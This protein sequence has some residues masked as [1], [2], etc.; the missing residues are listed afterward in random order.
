MFDSN[1]VQNY[2][3]KNS[4]ENTYHKGMHKIWNGRV[5]LPRLI[6]KYAGVERSLS[7]DQRGALK[8]ILSLIIWGEYAAWQTSNYLASDIKEYSAKMAA[9]SQAHDEA[10]HYFTMCDYIRNILDVSTDNVKISSVGMV[11]LESVVM[12]DSLAKRLL[13][14]QLMVEPVAITI[15]HKLRELDVEPVL[16][17]LLEYYIRDEA[18]HIALG[19]RHLPKVLNTMTWP[20]IFQLFIWQAKLLKFEIDGLMEIKDS[21]I[22]LGIDPESL[23]QEAKK[24]QIDAAIEMKEQMNWNIPIETAISQVCDTYWKYK[25]AI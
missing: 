13:G 18:R 1:F 8:D 12:A 11:G 22:T 25:S 19:V 5:L 20:Q 2:A 16:T 23:F 7:E 15:F 14:M 21:L 6:K 3:N 4:L 10:R 9:V 17:E 24:R